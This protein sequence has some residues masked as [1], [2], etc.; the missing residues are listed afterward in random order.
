MTTNRRQHEVR[1]R[2][3]RAAIAILIVVAAGCK[4]GGSSPETGPAADAPTS[5]SA[6][7]PTGAIDV[8]LE[9]TIQAAINRNPPRTT[10]CIRSGERRLDRA[11]RPKSNNTLVF[12]EG[13]ILNGSIL[14]TNWAPEGSGWVATGMTQS[15]SPYDV[16][17][18]LNHAACEYEDLFM[19]DKPLVRVL[20]LSEL[21]PG[22]FFFDEAADRIYVAEDPAGHKVEAPVAKQAIHSSEA[23]NVTVRGATIEKFA[24]NG[25]AGSDG[26]KIQRNEIRYVHSHGLRVFGTTVVKGNYIHHTGNMGIFGSGTDMLFEGNHLAYNNYLNFGRKD[27]PWHA[28]ATKIVKSDGTIVRENYSHDNIGDGW[29]F[30]TDNINTLVEGNVFENNTRY[31]LFYET[32]FRAVVRNNEFTNNGTP[33]KW[34]GAGLWISNSKDMRIHDNVLSNNKYSALAMSW[35]DRGSSPL[36]GPYEVAN[37]F[38]HDNVIRMVDGFVGVPFAE[39]EIYSSNNRFEANRYVVA[40]PDGQWWRWQGE[41]KTWEQWQSLGFD[42]TGSVSPIPERN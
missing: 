26:W 40:D 11:I 21:A 14:V 2:N 39:T 31:G 33:Q 22:K 23:R 10:F 27:G 9:E 7:C 4:G 34:A 36:Y 38:V 1:R 35:V 13:S 15:F 30:D 37:V 41:G 24:V 17:C 19:D 6:K 42:T 29:W 12:E 28:G 8:A 25:I 32:S 3:L 5:A 20:N 16:P 18:E